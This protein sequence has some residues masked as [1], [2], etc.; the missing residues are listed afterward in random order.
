METNFNFTYPFYC[1]FHFNYAQQ[2]IDWVKDGPW[3]KAKNYETGRIDFFRIHNT[4]SDTKKLK[5][6]RGWCSTNLG[7]IRVCRSIDGR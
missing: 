5:H 2:T 6:L 7:K 3:V 4:L 1:S